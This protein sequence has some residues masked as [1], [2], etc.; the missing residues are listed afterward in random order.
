ML[1]SENT[2]SIDQLKSLI[3]ISRE[4]QRLGNDSCVYRHVTQTRQYR[5]QVYTKYTRR[6]GLTCET[7]SCS[8]ILYLDSHI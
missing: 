2:Y 7:T 3:L 6:E 4:A 5:V 8:T 1:C